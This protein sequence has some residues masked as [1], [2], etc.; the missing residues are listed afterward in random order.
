[1]KKGQVRLSTKHFNVKECN[2]R[3]LN[4]TLQIT[5]EELFSNPTHS[6]SFEEFLDF[7]GKRVKLKDFKG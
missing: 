7:I 2:N 3:V 5:E 1:M 4:F 6:E